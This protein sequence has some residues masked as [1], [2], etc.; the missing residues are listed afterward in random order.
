MASG[1]WLPE[2][3][4]RTFP[5]ISGICCAKPY[6][7]M[8]F[9]CVQVIFKS[10]CKANRAVS[11][12]EFWSVNTGEWPTE[13]VCLSRFSPCSSSYYTL[14]FFCWW[15]EKQSSCP[16]FYVCRD[17]INSCQFELWQLQFVVFVLFI[18]GE[19]WAMMCKDCRIWL[20]PPFRYLY[21][22]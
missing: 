7:N 21:V 18:A 9:V 17:H 14:L 13:P 5:Q 10:G 12:E 4:R 3:H 22:C 15:T 6:I 1:F 16:K 8:L 19:G 11:Q 2:R 20:Y